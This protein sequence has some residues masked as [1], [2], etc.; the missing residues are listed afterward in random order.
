[1]HNPQIL[2]LDE[3]TIGLD[4][5]QIRDVRRVIKDLGEGH[6][7]VLSTHILPEVEMICRRFL[8]LDQGKIV[9]K[10]TVDN[11]KEKTHVFVTFDDTP[12]GV[13]E[14]LASVPGVGKVRR[15]GPRYVL[16]TVSRGEGGETEIEKRIFRTAVDK[17]WTIT[18]LKRQ[19][20]TLEDVFVSATMKDHD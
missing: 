18:E 1:V 5:N 6:T 14:S 3:P 17:G 9:T 11:L 10:D 15:E 16:E 12:E 2:I 20:L 8:I 19:A 7:V 13:E 4:P